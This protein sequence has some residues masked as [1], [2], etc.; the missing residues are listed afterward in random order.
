MLYVE[1][2]FTADFVFVKVLINVR[3]KTKNLDLLVLITA[4]DFRNC[5]R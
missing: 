1:V 3:F 5:P 2:L 4:Y